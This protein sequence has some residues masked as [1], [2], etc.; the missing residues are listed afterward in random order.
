MVYRVAH[1]A[2]MVVVVRGVVPFDLA[3]VIDMVVSRECNDRML[4]DISRD[5]KG[6]RPCRR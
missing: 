3:A 1:T 4:Q 6:F 2:G 5:T